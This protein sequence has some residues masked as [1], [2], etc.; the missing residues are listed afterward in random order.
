MDNR[1]LDQLTQFA[2]FLEFLTNPEEAKQLLARLTEASKE[3]KVEV[4][5]IRGTKEF[6]LWRNGELAKLAEAQKALD[7]REVKLNTANAAKLAE[8]DKKYEQ[9]DVCCLRIEGRMS[10]INLFG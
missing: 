8:L 4:E 1:S 5:S 7:A 2:S 3:Y 6:Q 9:I 10:H